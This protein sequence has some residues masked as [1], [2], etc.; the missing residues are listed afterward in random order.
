MYIKLNSDGLS[1]IMMQ[2][3]K[4]YNILFI[5]CQQTSR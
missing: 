5:A 2:N 3:P 4:L 1:G